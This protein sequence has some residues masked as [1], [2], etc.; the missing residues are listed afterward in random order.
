MAKGAKGHRKTTNRYQQMLC[1]YLKRRNALR[2]RYGFKRN[3]THSEEYNMKSKYLTY[4]IGA[5]RRIL[6]RRADEQIRLGYLDELVEEFTDEKVKGRVEKGSK[7]SSLAK[8]LFFKAAIELGFEG[9][10]IIDYTGHINPDWPSKVRLDFTRSFKT[11]RYHMVMWHRFKAFI[12]ENRETRVLHA[13]RRKHSGSITR[14][15]D[16]GRRAA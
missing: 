6:R 8:K 5:I 13:P 3:V 1:N 16:E 15:E 14:G 4:R 11:N 7:S 10:A 9:P 12:D 2:K